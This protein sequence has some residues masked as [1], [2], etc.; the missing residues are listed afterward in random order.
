MKF[1]QTN[2]PGV[3]L[4]EPR[5]FKDS[6]GFFYESYNAEVF[7]EHGIPAT[8]IQDNHVWSC[9]GVLRGLHYQTPPKAQAKLV[10]VV[11]GRIFDVAV[12]LRKQSSTYGKS[13][14]VMLGAE[15]RRMIYIPEGFAHGYL[16]LEEETEVLYKV[17]HL[18]SPAHEAGILW[19]DPLLNIEW[20]KLGMDYLLSDKDQKLPFFKNA[21]QAD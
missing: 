17:T 4:V 5:A 7:K 18:Y 1:I 13:I 11:R 16:S 20:P 6:R 12:D 19:N 15:D 8:F 10:R 21:A 14:G 3:V 2:I 9:R